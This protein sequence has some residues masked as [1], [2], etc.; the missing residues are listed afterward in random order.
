[1]LWECKV[2]KVGACEVQCK[3]VV[4]LWEWIVCL[5][6][7]AMQGTLL[8]YV[9]GTQTITKLAIVSKRAG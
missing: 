3:V 4:S 6:V 2:V 5:R 1:M 8:S 7:V 9:Q